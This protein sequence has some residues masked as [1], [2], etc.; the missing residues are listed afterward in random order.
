MQDQFVYTSHPSRVVFGAGSSSTLADEVE[1]LGCRRALVLDHPQQ[2]STGA[3][4][5][6]RLGPL[7]AGLFSEAAMHTP[8]AVT[9]RA[10]QAFKAAGA[11]CTVAIGGG[12]TTGLGK[13]LALRPTC[14]R[15]SVPTT[16]AAR[17]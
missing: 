13:A 17:R 4:V 3:E 1:R 16:Y 14:R 5:V 7:A 12:S 10:L 6:S 11:D 9:E 2:Q 8:V 15:W